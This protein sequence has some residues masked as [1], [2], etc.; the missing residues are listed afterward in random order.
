MKKKTCVH[1]TGG[2][3]NQLF[4]YAAALTL[5][6]RDIYFE[7]ILGRPRSDRNK[8]PDLLALR[9]PTPVHVVEDLSR[10]KYFTEKACG[11]SLRSGVA[12]K[13]VEKYW[14]FSR[15]IETSLSIVLLIRNGS[16]FKISRGSGVGYSII[17]ESDQSQYLL[18]YFQSYKYAAKSL[19]QL[20]TLEP[21]E[22]GPQLVE[23]I[24]KAEV[25]EPLVVHFRLGDYLQEPT[26]GIP[27][28][29]YYSD[30]IQRSWNSGN[31]KSIWVFSDDI[32]NAKK[33]FPEN[34]VQHVRWIADVDESPASTFHAMRFGYGYVIANST[35]SWWG[36]YLSKNTDVPVIAPWPWFKG[37]ESPTELLPPSW[38]TVDSDF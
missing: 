3:G 38:L 29:H 11:F 1:L 6:T 22:L 27:G 18:G 34:F 32:S 30:A 35:F 26:F 7:T 31:Y 15:L 10:L 37:M 28:P 36:A 16:K 21:I 12:P 19:E 13:G 25:E 23:L 5:G 9:L 20:K 24:A 33:N 2:L 14:G 8:R 4:Q 17:Q